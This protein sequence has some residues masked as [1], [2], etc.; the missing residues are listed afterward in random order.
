MLQK[1][2]ELGMS[3]NSVEQVFQTVARETAYVRFIG[4]KSDGRRVA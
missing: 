2:L 3:G 4:R 1:A